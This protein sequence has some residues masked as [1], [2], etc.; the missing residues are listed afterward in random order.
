MEEKRFNFPVFIYQGFTV[1]RFAVDAKPREMAVH[2]FTHSYF[3]KLIS[4]SPYQ[5]RKHRYGETGK[6]EKMQWWVTCLQKFCGR[7]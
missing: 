7:L 3:K 1:C 4:I 5:G 6:A 2:L